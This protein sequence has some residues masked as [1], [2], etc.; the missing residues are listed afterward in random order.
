MSESKDNKSEQSI[1]LDTLKL[2][3]PQLLPC[4]G[5]LLLDEEK[6]GAI[7]ASIAAT[8]LDP[9][10]VLEAMKRS[11]A[12]L[13]A[14]GGVQAGLLPEPIDGFHAWASKPLIS[15]DK[16]K[17]L[18]VCLNKAAQSFPSASLTKLA[19]LT[20]VASTPPRPSHKPVSGMSALTRALDTRI[21]SKEI[22]ATSPLALLRIDLG[23]IGPIND[24]DGW[25]ASDALIDRAYM[26]LHD[27]VPSQCFTVHL[28][29]G[30]FAVTVPI[31]QDV[32]QVE[33]LANDIAA[34]L[35]EKEGLP[36]GGFPFE[37]Y[38][39]WACY[40]FDAPDTDTLIGFANAALARIRGRRAGPYVN[41]VAPEI[42]H[43]HADQIGMESDLRQAII[44]G[45]FTL[46]WLPVLETGT[47]HV[48]TF[49]A[50]V[51]WNR[52]GHGE[53]DPSVFLGCAENAGLI[54][55][56]DSWVLHT[57][58]RQ[59]HS[60]KEPLGLSVNVSPSWLATERVATTI[61]SALEDSGLD[62]LR[63]QIELSER[64]SFGASDIASKE[65]A[66]IRAMGVRLVLDDFGTGFGA[67][68]RLTNYPF[69]Q[70]KLDRTF[71]RRVGVDSRVETVL[72]STLYMI[73]SLNMTCC[74]E[75]VETEE[76]LGFLDA[77]GCEEIQGYLIG[78]PTLRL[79]ESRID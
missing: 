60:W 65:L 7:T 19:T 5:A 38:I 20:T 55:D 8:G 77:H 58:C 45:A 76:Q 56:I 69:D 46:N 42:A 35:Q 40:P 9:R 52:P 61:G 64:C 37:P 48:V 49:E 73:H 4:D 59:A 44:D 50:L 47:E 6:G 26:V 39:G 36:K 27:F 1:P 16:E 10:Q 30:S 62:P 34:L 66:R 13:S 11:T 63:L 28:G 25:P 74:A 31:T 72:R 32:S 43:A 75:G 22:S 23:R 24:S 53:V 2:L 41:R 78:Q 71:I 18:L 70:V 68:E 21:S 15:E 51:R 3:V 57:A 79:P 29:G 14:E 67:L 54:E 12:R 17:V 33:K